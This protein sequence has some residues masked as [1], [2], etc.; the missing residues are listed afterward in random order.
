MLNLHQKEI[1]FFPLKRRSGT[2]ENLF[3][4]VFKT[5]VEDSTCCS[6]Y[7]NH[8]RSLFL[9]TIAVTPNL[10]KFLERIYSAFRSFSIFYSWYTCS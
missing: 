3:R 8:H 9:P 6:N 5:L 2:G 7:S 4:V 1:G 10:A